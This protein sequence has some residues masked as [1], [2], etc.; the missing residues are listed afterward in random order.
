MRTRLWHFVIPAA[1]TMA[2]AVFATTWVFERDLAEIAYSQLVVTYLLV[3]LGLLLI[4]FV[5]PPSRFWIGGDVL[6][7]DRCNPALSFILFILFIDITILPLTQ[8]LFRLNTLQ[9]LT[10]YALIG[11]TVLIWIFVVRAIW[12][13]PWLS[14]YVGILSDR[15]G[16]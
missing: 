11:A 4:I 16:R 8:E 14:R 9:D 10:H 3:A 1:V 5:Q 15:L 7:R 13:A 12:R 6:S 2:V